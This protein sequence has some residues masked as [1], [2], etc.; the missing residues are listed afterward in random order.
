MEIFMCTDK[1]YVMPCGARLYSICQNNQDA[2][3]TFHIVIDESINPSMQASS[4]NTVF[5]KSSRQV[6]FYTINGN[7]FSYLPR[8]DE[9]PPNYI[10][11]TSYL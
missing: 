9:P 7:D 10:T 11:K 2:A 5:P 8:I 3:I 4:G 1:N 6:Q